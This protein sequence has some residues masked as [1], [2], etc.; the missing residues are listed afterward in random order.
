MELSI[1]YAGHV[2]RNKFQKA[3]INRERPFYWRTVMPSNSWKSATTFAFLLFVLLSSLF[4]KIAVAAT[5]KLD[6]QTDKASYD[7]E[8]TVTLYR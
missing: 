3:Y 6:I 1:R 5:L 4:T 2:G 7:L 8:E